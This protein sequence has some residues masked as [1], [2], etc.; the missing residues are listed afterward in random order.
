MA[1]KPLHTPNAAVNSHVQVSLLEAEPEPKAHLSSPVRGAFASA[2]PAAG[3]KLRAPLLS[4]AAPSGGGTQLTRASKRQ[5]QQLTE[6]THENVLRVRPPLFRH[7]PLR[8][9]PPRRRQHI[10]KCARSFCF[11]ISSRSFVFAV[12]G[13]RGLA[14]R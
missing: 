3:N 12:R 10:Y 14:V 13:H 5:L 7:T 1:V 9:L 4:S 2:A 11:W 8:S 6:L